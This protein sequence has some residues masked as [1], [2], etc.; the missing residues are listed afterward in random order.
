MI[1]TVYSL[2]VLGGLVRRVLLS[3]LLLLLSKHLLFD[4][5]SVRVLLTLLFV[6]HFVVF[7]LT[8]H[9]FLLTLFSSTFNFFLTV[10]GF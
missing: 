9:F 8:H 10:I 1:P 5:F 6:L 7:V 2:V 4:L 3:K